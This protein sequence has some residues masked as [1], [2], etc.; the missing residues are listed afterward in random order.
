MIDIK[1]DE[2]R[3]KSNNK[4]SYDYEWVYEI[5]TVEESNNNDDEGS[6]IPKCKN[7]KW[8]PPSARKI[9][10]DFFSIELW[11]LLRKRMEE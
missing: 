11:R 3:M 7:K 4:E 1:S 8:L 2:G 6:S 5:L 9:Q 10:R